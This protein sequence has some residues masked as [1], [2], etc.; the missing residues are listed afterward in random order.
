MPNH[1]SRSPEK[2]R[3]P[4]LPA[5]LRPTAAFLVL[6][7]GL[8]WLLSACDLF[9]RGLPEPAA[10]R[11]EAE[12]SGDLAARFAGQATAL[13]PKFGW[14]N[15][16]SAPR[17]DVEYSFYLKGEN[18]EEIL[19]SLGYFFP[20]EDPAPV[21]PP[22]GKFVFLPGGRGGRGADE[23]VP[24]A[25]VVTAGGGVLLDGGWVRVSPA[26]G[27]GVRGEVEGWGSI[28]SLSG[29]GRTAGGVKAKFIALPGETTPP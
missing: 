23:V 13:P 8:M 11:F 15:V 20:G 18:G 12:A 2:A 1:L 27:G 19:I 6:V 21:D 26:P 5:L 3:S 17:R 7:A 24:H 16:P 29:V 22:F 9:G 14:S 10:G 4:V 25:S 28:G